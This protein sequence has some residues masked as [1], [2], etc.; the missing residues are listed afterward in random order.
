MLTVLRQVHLRRLVQQPLRTAVGVLAVAGGVALSLG[1]AVAQASVD[2]SFDDIGTFVTGPA[3]LR[4]RGPFEY[5]GLDE[6][7]AERVAAVDGVAATV[8]LIT[9]VVQVADADGDIDLVAAFGIDCSIEV[10]FG[11]LGCDPALLAA[12]E[13]GDTPLVAPGYLAELGPGAVVHTDA[14]SI[15]LDGAVQVA[16]FDEVN[17]SRIVVWPVGAAQRLL[18]REGRLDQLLVVPEPDTDPGALRAA[19]EAAAGDNNVVEGAG[20]PIG[21]TFVTEQLLPGLLL[22]SLAGVLVGIQLVHST[23]ALAL[24]ER[25]KELAVAAAVGARPRVAF[26]GLLTEAAA[27]GAVG[28]LLGVVGARVVGAAYVGSLSEQVE[29]LSGLHLSTVVPMW[30][31]GLGVAVGVAIAVL[32]AV[33]PER[34]A[35]RLDLAAELSE[36]EQHDPEPGR[37]RVALAVAMSLIALG[38]VL[39]W[40]G[41]R[42]GTLETWQPIAALVG[43]TVASTAAYRLPGLLIGDAV[44]WLG[45]T[46]LGQRNL[47]GVAIGNLRGEPKR[48]ASIANALGVAAALTVTI[49]AI[50][51]GVGATARRDVVRSN[52]DHVLVTPQGTNNTLRIDSRLAP[53]DVAA[54]AAVP[55]VAGVTETG[56]ALLDHPSIGSVSVI[57]GDNP[58]VPNFDV[59]R[60]TGRQEALA[61]GRVM[62]GPALA[63]REGLR[64]GDRF[65]LPGVNGAV[66]LT[67]GGVWGTAENIGSSVHLPLE[68]FTALTGGRPANF[69]L[70]APEPGVGLRELADRVEAAGIDARIEA[71]DPAELG[72]TLAG[73]IEAFVEP[74]EAV[75]RALLVVAFVATLSTLLLAAV[76]RRRELATLAAVGMPPGDLARM[77]LAEAAIVGALATVVGTAAGLVGYVGFVFLSPSVT[78]LP[79]QWTVPVA[80]VPFVF[81]LVLTVAVA[82]AAWPAWRSTRIEPAVALRYE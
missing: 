76:Q 60:G 42:D 68:Q 8:P 17:D 75:Q 47:V 9:T 52:G 14:A 29:R 61:A 5:A 3:T 32:A 80:V 24:E 40:L 20:S 30:V 44:G 51:P 49:G 50:V 74:F 59:Y 64:P 63:R 79:L 11:E 45:R 21:T 10:V 82:G 34:A 58:D 73:E 2:R 15:P 37:R 12:A 39:G 33:K 72:D 54:L 19:V 28:G 27:L 41:W 53:D 70:L 23:F 66:E 69:H 31:V 71:Y 65:S 62:I 81:A 55:G 35:A 22:T 26:L 7:V 16:A 78:G 57:G 67:V 4:V 13:A 48:T 77:T 43:I 56:F 18:G 6:R 25:R 36:R 46:S 38:L 1:V